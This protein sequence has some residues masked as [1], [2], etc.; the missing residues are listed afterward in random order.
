MFIN[1]VSGLGGLTRASIGN[2]YKHPELHKMLEKTALETYAV[3]KAKGIILPEDMVKNV[4]HFISKQPYDA[5]ASTQRDLMEGR[6]SELD[7]F[8]GYVVREGEKLGIPTPVNSFI[9]NCLQPMEEKA[10]KAS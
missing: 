9:Y 8:N 2:M 3:G 10:R 4:M 6:P 7:N 1:T 5:T